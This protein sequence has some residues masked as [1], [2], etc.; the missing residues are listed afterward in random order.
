MTIRTVAIILTAAVLSC[1]IAQGETV[2]KTGDGAVTVSVSSS[3]APDR[4]GPHG[5]WLGVRIS[6][7]PAPLAAHLLSKD[8]GAM[9]ANLVKDSPAHKAGVKQYDVIVGLDKGPVKDGQSL[10]KTLRNRKA[11]QKIKLWVMREGKKIQIPVTLGKPVPV[12]KVQLVHKENFPGPWNVQRDVMRLHPHVMLRKKAGDWEKM[13]GKDLPEEIR[14]MLKSIP[15]NV[16]P[17]ANPNVSVSAK[18][19]IHTK[20]SDGDDV[21]IEQDETGKITVTRKQRDDDGTEAA[22]TKTYKDRE[23]LRLSDPEAFDLLK[24]S[25]VKV[26][27]SIKAGQPGKR[28]GGGMPEIRLFTSG[29][30]AKLSREIHEKILKSI[31]Q[32]NLPDDVK[33]SLRKQ[34][35]SQLRP[36]GDKNK[37]KDEDKP[38]PRKKRKPKTLKTPKTPRKPKVENTSASHV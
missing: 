11:G 6:P 13:D 4:P 9:V 37:D 14:K 12:D 30:H 26:F 16:A 32:M 25:N 31:E 7:V 18:T 28:P 27:T 2:V 17:G 20:N 38:K 34:L 35:Q 21:R 19:V 1:G 10:I 22:E 5:G 29:D 8:I 36:D 15:K 24:K 23:Q 33:E 3:A